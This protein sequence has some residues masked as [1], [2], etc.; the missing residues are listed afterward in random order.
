[1][2]YIKQIMSL[3]GCDKIDAMEIYDR[4]HIDFSECT[5]SEFEQAVYQAL[6]YYTED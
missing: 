5:D 1:M 6:N 3:L 4:M 2:F